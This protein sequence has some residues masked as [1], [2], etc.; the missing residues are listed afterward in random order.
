MRFLPLAAPAA[1]LLLA[2]ASPG[3]AK[4]PPADLVIWGGPIYTADDAHPTAQAVAVV[5]GRIAYV[6]AKA[7]AAARVGP[8]TRVVDL[9][10]AALFP[11]FTDSHA[12]LREIG[13]RE[14]TLN[15]EG[16][17]SAAEVAQRLKAWIA[18]HPG[19]REIVG[20]G[21]IE[22]GWPEGRFLQR[23]DIDPV[24]GDIPV[25]MRRADGHALVANTAALKAAHIDESTPAPQGG[26]ILKGP[27]GKL[28]GM[29]VD[30]AMRLVGGERRPGSGVDPELALKAAFR[31]ETAYGWTGVHSMSVA[32][33][34]V[35]L[36]EAM[37]KRGEASAQEIFLEARELAQAEGESAVVAEVA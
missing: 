2:A 11:G 34:D 35:P 36:L 23:S 9:K 21:W 31:V 16:S 8:K 10:G 14:L 6:G 32:W 30:N 24:S 28:T 37:A 12:H 7:G 15:V 33:S 1:L 18:S 25:L 26:Q 20:R 5:R 29:L 17:K 27:D 3:A 4:P 13:D 22:T 19:Q